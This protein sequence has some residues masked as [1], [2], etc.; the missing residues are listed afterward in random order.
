MFVPPLKEYKIGG[1]AFSVF[2]T[3]KHVAKWYVTEEKT[4]SPP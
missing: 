4:Q 1:L 2:G 3:V